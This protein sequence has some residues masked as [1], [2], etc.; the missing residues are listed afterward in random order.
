MSITSATGILYVAA[1]DDEAP[2]LP[3]LCGSGPGTYRL[4]VHAR[5]R[6]SHP[7][8]IVDEVPAGAEPAEQYLLVT[9]PADAAPASVHQT[10]DQFGQAYRD[11]M[12][13]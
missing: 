3:N 9:W 2:G 12:A 13:G 5:G 11:S 10:R 8:E 6:D 7:S 1:I 4:R